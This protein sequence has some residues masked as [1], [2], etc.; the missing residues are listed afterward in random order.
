MTNETAQPQDSTLTEAEVG[1]AYRKYATTVQRRCARRLCD[2]ALAQDAVQEVFIRL[3]RYGAGF[4]IAESE[5]WW[6][7]RVAD[8]VCWDLLRRRRSQARERSGD[9]LAELEAPFDHA[10]DAAHRDVIQRFFERFD[11]TMRELAWLH[12]VAEIP[13][14][15]IGRRL[16]WSRQTVNRKLAFVN[17]RAQTLRGSL[18]LADRN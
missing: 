9:S 15:E 10:A 5:A 2:D 11:E 14:G 17:Q 16:G 1:A 12:F 8:R 4:R 3:L 6:L 7:Y 13:Q 18:G